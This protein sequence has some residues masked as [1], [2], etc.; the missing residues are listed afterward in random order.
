MPER[1]GHAVSWIE[2]HQQTLLEGKF[3]VQDQTMETAMSQLWSDVAREGVA[4]EGVARE[5]VARGGV[6][7]GGVARGGVARGGVAREEEDATEA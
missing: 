1:A 4:R 2:T 3:S 7:R 6:A 5:G